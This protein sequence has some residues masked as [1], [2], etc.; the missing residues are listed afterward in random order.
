MKVL[1]IRVA[2]CGRFTDPVALEGLTGGLDLLV[3]P[4]EAGKSTLMRALRAVLFER[5]RTTQRE[6]ESLRP[7]RGGAPLIEVDLEIAGERWRV[8]KR[9]LADRMAE[10]VS[11]AT[12]AVTRAADAEAQLERLLDVAETGGRYPLL[13]LGQGATLEP[14]VPGTAGEAVLD[15]AISREVASAAG[16][17][18]ARQVRARVEKDLAEL[19]SA[20]RGQRRGRWLAATKAAQSAEVGLTEARRA[21]AEVEDLLARLGAIDAAAAPLVDPA[22]KA[23]RHR[24]AADVEARF[25]QAHADA[26]DRDRA[27]AAVA[28]ARIIHTATAGEARKLSDGL[29]ELA[30]MVER[31]RGEAV[32]SGTLQ[33]AVATA[34]AHCESAAAAVF[35][36]RA[37]LAAAEGALKAIAAAD[38]H[39]EIAARFDRARSAAGRITNLD[40]TLSG[41]P[42]GEAPVREARRLFGR[43]AEA[44]GR[45][46]AASAAVTIAYEPGV[47]DGISLAGTSLAGGTRLV[48]ESPL[49]LEIAGI[50]RITIEPGTSA[51]RQELLGAVAADRGALANILAEAGVPDIA[52][53]EAAHDRARDLAGE[54]AEADAELKALAPDGLMSLEALMAE[55]DRLISASG[56]PAP[57]S[58]IE[59]I[60]RD[61][62]RFRADLDA[63]DLA[64]RTAEAAREES[65]RLVSMQ[66]A[67]TAERNRR[68][69]E[70]EASLPPPELRQQRRV[71][72]DAAAAAASRDLDDALR[73][74]SAAEARALDRQGL[75]RL[76]ADVAA[77]RLAIQQAGQEAATLGA[78]RARIEGSL[79]RARREDIAAR[80]ANLEA[81][82]ERTCANLD[83]I[84]EEVAALQ[85]LDAELGAEEERLRDSYLA[86]VSARLAPYLDVVLPGA[87]V[88]LGEGYR[89][90]GVTRGDRREELTRLSDGTREQISV[91][92]RLAFAR[93]LADQGMAVPLILDDALVYSDDRRIAAMHRVLELASEAHQV[94][95]LTCREQ[96]FAGLDGARVELV[97]W[98]LEGR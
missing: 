48:A 94:I 7:Y 65:R 22:A 52:A 78:E 18:R 77:A 37:G 87:E 6:I 39:R 27:G 93:L 64:R 45:I 57:G 8:R 76:D 9:F 10:V 26:A 11:L 92:V 69:A 59:E 14:V 88:A 21:H 24:R 68:L 74:L 61:V 32:E 19:M 90:S 28:E 97:P 66:A 75:E 34:E 60:Q 73:L 54:R 81:E 31:A 70:M 47:A 85:L 49:V 95:V 36:A 25:R 82:V 1:A 86:P 38:R 56:S 51:D 2:E 23:A 58:G 20:A 46:E 16:G 83:D 42:R 33:R 30:E 80:L 79:E 53:L 17:D 91:L 5:H 89:V 55:A 29:A 98:R 3:G 84:E 50:G 41:L 40:R 35:A 71:E 96:S 62:E 15:A 72:L 43:I 63:A 13:W 4:N 12:G 44:E 67:R